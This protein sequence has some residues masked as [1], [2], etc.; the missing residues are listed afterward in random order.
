L[1]L[2]AVLVPKMFR[3]DCG[4]VPLPFD[5]AQY[6]STRPLRVG[7][8][9][10]DHWFEPCPT[11]KR[12]VREA[13]A[14]LGE[15]GHTCVPFEPPTDGW[16]HYG[17]LVAINGAE[18]NMR[19]FVEALEDEEVIPEYNLLLRASRLPYWLS[20]ILRRVVDPRL[21]HLLSKT[22]SGGIQVWELWQA[23]AEILEMRNAWHD[24]MRANALDA[25]VHP[26]MP[27]PAFPHGMGTK[28]NFACSYL[29]IANLLMWPSGA[30][31]VTTIRS[32]EAF[33]D[34]PL[35]QRDKIARGAALTMGAGSVGL[36]I[37]VCVM[38]MN[39]EDEK[40][41]R[42]MKDIERLVGFESR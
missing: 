27:L 31:P 10:T 16:H 9:E 33:Y 18:G 7:Y 34:P 32:D 29:M 6:S 28:L 23:A 21:A 25:L 8:F 42:L 4:V 1:F 15:A 37:S 17:L 13:V 38:T 39:Y 41:L 19:S 22:R 11:A 30:V 2:R 35:P 24:A 12:A 3:G 40:C 36:P 5:D 26:A 14:A 20:C